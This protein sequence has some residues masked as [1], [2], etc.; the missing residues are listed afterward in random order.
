MDIER[1]YELYFKDIFRYLF[2]LTRDK[3]LAE[4]ITQDTFLKAMKSID[5]Y[6]GDNIKSWLFTI[7]KNTFFTHYNRQKKYCEKEAMLRS[8]CDVTED[9]LEELIQKETAI[10]IV[11]YVDAL[12]E[13]YHEVFYLRNYGELSFEAI[14]ARYGKTSGWARTVYYRA[15]KQIAELMK[16]KEN[17]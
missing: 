13:P 16:E 2:S 15:K 9:V 12:K 14:G 17:E 1:I 3:E 11:E 4:D 10:K 8:T 7:A 5:M 6:S